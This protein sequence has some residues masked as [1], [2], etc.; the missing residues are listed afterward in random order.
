[1]ATG[2]DRAEMAYLER[3][4]QEPLPVWGLV[5]TPL[6]YILLDRNGLADFARLLRAEIAPG[7]PDFLSRLAR[8]HDRAARSF[9][10]ALRRLAVARCLPG[11]LPRMLRRVLPARCAYLNVGH[12]NL[13]ERVLKAV[14]TVPE[15]RIAVMI[16]DVIPL[17]HPDFQRAGSVAP[18]E[19]KLRRVR[20][21]ADVI[22]YNSADTARKTLDIL[23]GWGAVP[24]GIVA[25]L[26]T[27][28]VAPDPGGLPDGLPPASPYFITVGTIEPRKNHALLLDVWEALGPDAPM[29]L[30][31][32]NRGWRNE[33]VFARLDAMPPTGPVREVAGL[34][35]GAL[36]ALVEGA[37]ALLFPSFAE[38][39]GLPAVEALRLGTPVLC[40]NIETFREVLGD[41]AVY[42]ETDGWQNWKCRVVDWSKRSREEIRISNFEAPEWDA[43]FKIALSYT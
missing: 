26:G 33:D 6:G 23:A 37:H 3:L 30:I 42:L 2:I 16:H 34:D 20:R 24:Q 11:G 17:T 18:F 39:F 29:L 41:S 21:Y 31:A 4:V 27:T 9:Q 28:P 8:G 13:T 32:G 19:A 35:D 40:S 5:R 22:L 38:G 14:R 1:M 10:S 7:P 36:A 25:H 43:H 12:S 15:A